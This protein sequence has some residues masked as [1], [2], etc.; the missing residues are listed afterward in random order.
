MLVLE[1]VA[2]AILSSGCALALRGAIRESIREVARVD[3][4]EASK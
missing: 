3:A 2:L 1:L 4:L